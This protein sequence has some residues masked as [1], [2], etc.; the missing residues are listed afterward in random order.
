VTV[1]RAKD[2]AHVVSLAKIRFAR[3]DLKSDESSR[4]N[5]VHYDFK[6]RVNSYV[7]FGLAAKG[8]SEISDR[9]LNRRDAE[10]SDGIKMHRSGTRYRLKTWAEP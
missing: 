10:T 6:L 2:Y 7:V 1:V 9:A 4:D 8:T 3:L 5:S